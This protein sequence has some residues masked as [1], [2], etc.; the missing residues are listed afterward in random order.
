MIKYKDL[1]LVPGGTYNQ[2]TPNANIGCPDNFNH[3]I[4]SFKIAKYEVTYELWYNVIQWGI[5]N[6]Y[7]F[8][9]LGSEGNF[10]ITGN[11]PT[12]SKHEPVT[13][14]NWRDIIVWCNAYSEMNNLI[15]YCPEVLEQ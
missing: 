5:A 11:L 8:L 6:G 15:H 14:I 9:N 1:V 2:K 10:G 12:S 3:T 7:T 4:S 13:T